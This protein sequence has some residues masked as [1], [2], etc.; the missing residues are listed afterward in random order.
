MLEIGVCDDDHLLLL[1]MEKDL[2]DLGYENGV[3]LEI[4]TYADG[5]EIVRAVMRGKRFDIIFMDI[6]MK[7]LSGLSAAKKIREVD[8]TA[9]MVFVTSH[10]SYMKETFL[11]TPIGFLVKPVNKEEFTD[12]FNYILKMIGREDQYYRFR[13]DRADYKVLLKEVVYFESKGRMTEIVCNCGRYR[14]YKNLETIEEE[15]KGQQMRF[16][17]IHKSYLVSFCY[18]ARFSA[19]IVELMDGICLP[20]SRSRKKEVEVNLYE[21]MEWCHV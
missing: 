21:A 13:Y 7:Q 1:E 9:Q 3:N 20:V 14:L 12:I 19:E 5:E 17:R 2:L 6:E 4:H 11:A 8:R 10:E 16:V 15:L 18:I